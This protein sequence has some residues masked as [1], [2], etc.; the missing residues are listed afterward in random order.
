MRGPGTCLPTVRCS[1]KCNFASIKEVRARRTGIKMVRKEIGL[2]T[3]VVHLDLSG[4]KIERLPV[5]ITKMEG[6][7]AREHGR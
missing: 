2:L 5:E 6:A 3:S 1:P 7:G 4:N